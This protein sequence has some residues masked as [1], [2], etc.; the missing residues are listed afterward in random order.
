MGSYTDSS[1]KHE[2][3]TIGEVGLIGK[4]LGGRDKRVSDACVMKSKRPV[5]L[6]SKERKSTVQSDIVFAVTR[7]GWVQAWNV[8]TRK[9][10]P[11]AVDLNKYF[12]SEG[13]KLGETT[14]NAEFELANPDSGSTEC[15]Y[16]IKAYHIDADILLVV[17][18]DVIVGGTSVGARVHLLKMSED[19]MQHLKVFETSIAADERLVDFDL[20]QTYFPEKPVAI[21]EDS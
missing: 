7:D 2:E 9:Q 17:G 13:K 15:F 8:E 19:H 12:A 16:S 11:S 10:L 14:E 21:E 4:L 5:N 6:I 18:C 20:I 3:Y 1:D